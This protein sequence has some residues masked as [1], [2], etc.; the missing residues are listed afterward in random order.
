[1]AALDERLQGILAEATDLAEAKTKGEPRTALILPLQ[2]EVAA[3]K[4]GRWGSVG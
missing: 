3:R 4:R 2:G 1:M